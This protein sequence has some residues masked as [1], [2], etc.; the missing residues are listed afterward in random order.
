MAIVVC[1]TD[2]VTDNLTDGAIISVTIEIGPKKRDNLP[3][4]AVCKLRKQ[5]RRLGR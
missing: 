4:D 3:K 1:V 2:I 5:R